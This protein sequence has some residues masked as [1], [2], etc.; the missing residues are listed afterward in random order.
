MT[1][2]GGRGLRRVA[3]AMVRAAA[4]DT[5]RLRMALPPV[6]GKAAE[7]L[8]QA[9]PEFTEVV[10]SPVAVRGS[11]SAPVVVVPATVAERSLGAT[12][13]AAV[14]AA[15]AGAAAVVLCDGRV[16]GVQTVDELMGSGGV[17]LYR[18]RCAP[19]RS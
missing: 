14:Q 5:V 18:V 17:C 6:A 4:G 13:A 3:E 7:Q 15:L 8:G 9:I 11:A 19:E 12:G 2:R 1:S 16:L 10:L